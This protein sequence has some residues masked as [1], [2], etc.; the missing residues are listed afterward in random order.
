MLEDDIVSSINNSL[1]SETQG[2]FFKDIFESKNIEGTIGYDLK[3]LSVG[4][5]NAWEKVKTLKPTS[6]LS[7]DVDALTVISRQLDDADLMAKIGADRYDDIIKKYAG[8]CK[9]C[10]PPATG[11]SESVKHLPPHDEMLE[12]LETFANKHHGKP[13][14]DDVLNDLKSTDPRKQK[15]SEF[16]TRILKDNDDIAAFEYQYIGGQNNTADWITLNGKKID[17]KS[18]SVTSSIDNIGNWDFPTQLKDYFANPPFELWFDH[19]RFT[20]SSNSTYQAMS[21]AEATLHVKK[22]YQKLFQKPDKAE[23]LFNHITNNGA[24]IEAFQ[25]LFGVNNV[26]SFLSDVVPYLDNTALYGAFKVK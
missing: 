20:K 1:D 17:G 11:A 24:N 19:L 13:G 10:D 5:V 4:R 15:G 3:Q 9:T 7:T 21:K 8:Q 26:N 6:K 12:S 16:V 18:W 22:Q 23:E 25:D 14:L 2:R